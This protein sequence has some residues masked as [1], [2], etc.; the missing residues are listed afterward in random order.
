MIL[1]L[2]VFSFFLFFATR[3]S[4]FITFV[5]KAIFSRFASTTFMII[6]QYHYKYHRS[7]F[8]FS[9]TDWQVIRRKIKWNDWTIQSYVHKILS[10][11]SVANPF[12]YSKSFLMK[13]ILQTLN[14]SQIGCRHFNNNIKNVSLSIGSFHIKSIRFD[15]ICEHL[16]MYF[17]C[18]LIAKRE[19]N[20]KYK[21]KRLISNWCII[22]FLFLSSYIKI[23]ILKTAT[24]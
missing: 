3:K 13:P 21:F 18:F 6:I 8:L 9:P 12:S 20:V 17:A 15:F 11:R 7:M 22:Y 1:W 4:F 10:Q 16:F 19:C 5:W 24:H 23:M 14:F 2:F